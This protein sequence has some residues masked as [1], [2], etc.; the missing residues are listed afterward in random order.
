MTS[1][2]EEE[3]KFE[4]YNIYSLPEFITESSLFI[5]TLDM[6]PSMTEFHYD[7]NKMVVSL[8]IKSHEDFE[9]LIDA[10]QMFG[11]TSKVQIQLLENMYNFWLDDPNSSQLPLPV[12]DFSHF[13]N[14]VRALFTELN[15]ILPVRCF[16]GNYVELFDYLLNRDGLSTVDGGRWPD[17]TLPFYGAVC[18]NIEIVKRG[19]EIGVSIADDVIDQA[20]KQKNLEM[21]WL[22]VNHKNVRYTNKTL[23]IAAKEGLLEMYK[24]F[25]GVAR[26]ASI[27][28]IRRYVLKTLYN[29]ANL[30]YLLRESDVNLRCV[31]GLELLQECIR[32]G[33]SAE[34]IQLV[35]TSFSELDR[36]TKP[37]IYKLQE[38]EGFANIPEKV[39]YNED[40]EL[41]MYLQSKGFLIRPS[42]ID[43]VR[44][45]HKSPK[46]TPGFLKRQ[47][48]DQEAALERKKQEEDESIENQI[49]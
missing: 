46:F 1:F 24:H 34:I 8:K 37:L 44:N 33:L 25:L 3:D 7:R 43:Y 4:N 12:K 41:F 36:D 35:D 47:Y 5:R 45:T 18:N 27:I 17:Y 28:S 21:F 22:L 26:G 16:Q 38:I 23:D 14:Q 20:I 31:N 30:E 49:D 6:C 13:G 11:F 9:K 39:V 19:L 10:D 48:A 15:T 32:E 40:L 42:L 2:A 29:K